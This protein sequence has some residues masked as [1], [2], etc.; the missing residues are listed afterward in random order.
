MHICIYAQPCL[1][2]METEVLAYI[3][4]DSLRGHTDV[5]QTELGAFHGLAQIYPSEIPTSFYRLNSTAH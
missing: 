2:I 5:V 1:D 4:E 3:L